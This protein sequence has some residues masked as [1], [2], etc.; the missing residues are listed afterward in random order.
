MAT[1]NPLVLPPGIEASVFHQFI[2]EATQV[3][4]SENVT[5]IS[6]PSQ[7]N[8]NDYKDPSKVHDMFHITD[9]D[10][11][12]SSATITPG[13]VAE[14][15]AIV[16]LCNKFEIPLW[17]FSVGRNVGY[18]GAAPRVPGSIGLDLGKH[19][20]KILKVDVEGAYA[21]VEPGVTYMDLH[22]YLVDNGLRDKLWIDVPDL[23]GGSVLGNTTERGVGYTPYGELSQTSRRCSLTNPR[24]ATT[25]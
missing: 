4:G 19:M 6:S 24:Q 17:P 15:Q 12:V 22:Q 10:H 25:L 20:N 1:A 3:T 7:L 14:V 18:G 2:T 16:K 8:K 9:A 21:L 5:I 11:F 13:D 23:G